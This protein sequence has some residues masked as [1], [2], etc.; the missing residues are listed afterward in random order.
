M[1]GRHCPPNRKYIQD[2]LAR[3]F[4]PACIKLI[5]IQSKPIERVFTCVCSSFISD[6]P[7]M[8]LYPI[9]FISI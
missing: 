8:F 3:T 9:F 5:Y 6:S 1:F 4:L 7:R 2:S